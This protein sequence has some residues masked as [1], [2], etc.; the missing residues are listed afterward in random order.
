MFLNNSSKH[1]SIAKILLDICPELVYDYYEG[2]EY[3]GEGCLHFAIIQDNLEAVELLLNTK[4]L[5][6]HARARGKFFLPVDVKRGD[7]ILNKKQFQGYA[8]YGEYPLSFAASLGNHKVY[9][10]L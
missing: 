7:V 10:M 4:I 9:D 1:I 2:T 3:Y 5:D 8:Y 6:L